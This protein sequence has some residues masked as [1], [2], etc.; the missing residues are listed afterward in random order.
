MIGRF[1]KL[2]VKKLCRTIQ[3]SFILSERS[4]LTE[5]IIPIQQS[6]LMQTILVKCC[7]KK[8]FQIL[9]HSNGFNILCRWNW[10]RCRKVWHLFL[11]YGIDF[12]HHR[13][14]LHQ[15]YLTWS[16]D[17]NVLNHSIYG[18]P[19]MGHFSSR[20]GKNRPYS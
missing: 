7:K 5:I 8:P 19:F 9:F 10:M 1:I 12:L 15:L 16:P 20:G 18:E 17:Q 6:C 4:H 2:K 13:K 14:W 11:P 3:L